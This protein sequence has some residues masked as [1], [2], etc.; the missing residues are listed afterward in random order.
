[1]FK[2]KNCY[3]PNMETPWGTIFALQFKY[4]VYSFHLYTYTVLTCVPLFTN[5]K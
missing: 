4:D 1:M 2:S 5:M 3:L